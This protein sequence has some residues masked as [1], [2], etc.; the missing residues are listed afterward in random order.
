LDSDGIYE[1]LSHAKIQIQ[2]AFFVGEIWKVKFE[3]GFEA[4]VYSF[5]FGQIH[6]F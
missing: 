5:S 1:H 6:G 4:F 2:S 3:R